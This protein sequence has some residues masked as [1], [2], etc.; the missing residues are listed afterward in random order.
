MLVEERVIRAVTFLLELGVE[1]ERSKWKDAASKHQKIIQGF[2][3]QP[4]RRLG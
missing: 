3:Q 4:S 1:K 2:K